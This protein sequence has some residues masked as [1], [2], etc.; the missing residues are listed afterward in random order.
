MPSCQGCAAKVLHLRRAQ[1]EPGAA[2]IVTLR[3][4]SQFLPSKVQGWIFCEFCPF[5][6]TRL[7]GKEFSPWLLP[8][9][10]GIRRCIKTGLREDQARR[11][12]D[13]RHLISVGNGTKNREGMLQRLLFL[14]TPCSPAGNQLLSQ[15]LFIASPLFSGPQM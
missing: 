5:V 10:P 15:N 3:S 1:Q 7:A 8:R 11:G 14:D 6:V 4:P 9:L 13:C 12:L 2:G